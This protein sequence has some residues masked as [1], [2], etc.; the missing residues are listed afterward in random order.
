MF[1]YSS[2]TAEQLENLPEIIQ[3]LQE[4][5]AILDNKLQH[6]ENYTLL[7]ESVA[8]CEE[9]IETGRDEI[10]D[11]FEDE[12]LEPGYLACKKAVSELETTQAQSNYLATIDKIDQLFDS[13]KCEKNNHEKFYVKLRE[14]LDQLPKQSNAFRE[15]SQKV[16]E[17]HDS[18]LDS[19]SKDFL[20]VLQRYGYPALEH[21]SVLNIDKNMPD[22][23]LIQDLKEKLLLLSPMNT[24]DDL[25]DTLIS[26]FSDRFT[27]HFLRKSK[28]NTFSNPEWWLFKLIDW[29]KNHQDFINDFF[30]CK[31]KFQTGLVAL[32]RTKLNQ[33]L[34]S[35]PESCYLHL[36][37]ELV[38]FETNLQEFS[39]IKAEDSVLGILLED[40]KIMNF[41]LHEEEQRI[42]QKVDQVFETKKLTDLPFVLST[43]LQ[44]LTKRYQI[45]PTKIQRNFFYIQTDALSN[46]F[47]KLQTSNSDLISI[48]KVTKSIKNSIEKWANSSNFISLDEDHDLDKLYD[49]YADFE[50]DASIRIGQKFNTEISPI[51][52]TYATN[53]SLK[54]TSTDE[55]S[56]ACISTIR[57]L[58]TLVH[59]ID[60]SLHNSF[61]L[62][63]DKILC[64]E[65]FEKRNFSKDTLAIAEN[66]INSG[67]ANLFVNIST[68]V[69]ILLKILQKIKFLLNNFHRY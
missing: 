32:G 4:K 7:R 15:A 45:L 69:K 56:E 38:Q 25:I 63:L 48:L 1:D 34:A 50:N 26:P 27:Q 43:L 47:Q 59:E 23:I 42:L 55:A 31:D 17:F 13:A 37:S 68:D 58:S 9:L 65:I 3:G 66:D 10:C 39:N 16:Q 61:V 46:V 2:I 28:V 62:E 52:R 21:D 30:S 5:L 18:V 8:K 67:F 20:S 53:L 22:Y 11:A 60:E 64:S 49:K 19:V 33:D 36:I 12:T 6:D 24:E 14:N 44:E 29:L 41:W 35:T 40:K 51:I 54:H 57:D